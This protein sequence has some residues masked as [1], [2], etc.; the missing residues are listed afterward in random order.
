MAFLLPYSVALGISHLH[1]FVS[2]FGSAGSFDGRIF[3]FGFNTCWFF[4]SF[5]NIGVTGLGLILNCF[6]GSA[7]LP[8]GES[9]IRP[10][11]KSQSLLWAMS[12]VVQTLFRHHCSLW[13][14][15]WLGCTSDGSGDG[16]GVWRRLS[17]S[18]RPEVS[19]HRALLRIARNK[20]SSALRCER[21]SISGSR[22]FGFPCVSG[23]DGDGDGAYATPI[24]GCSAGIAGCLRWG[25]HSLGSGRHHAPGRRTLPAAS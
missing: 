5:V 4:V 8:V 20:A 24:V 9:P 11:Q 12:W 13:C 15:I 2:C 7:S 3:L 10:R 18:G 14:L 19:A 1:V 16:S 17:A 6:G 25:C 21:F 23:C 22:S